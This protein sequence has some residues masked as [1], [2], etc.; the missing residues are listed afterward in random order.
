[1]SGIAN[2]AGA[3]AA[4]TL[5]PYSDADV[6]RARRRQAAPAASHA[7]PAPAPAKPSCPCRS[8][9]PARTRRRCAPRRRRAPRSAPRAGVRPP[10]SVSLRSRSASVSPTHAIG[11][12]PAASAARAFAA[13]DRV[14][15]PMQLPALRMADDRIAASELGDHPGRHLARISARRVLADVLR[16][17]RAP[18]AP[19]APPAPARD[20]APERTRRGRAHPSRSRSSRRRDDRADANSRRARRSSSSCRQR[21]ARACPFQNRR[22][23]RAAAGRVN[24]SAW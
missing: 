8:P 20:T 3:L 13:N 10:H 22:F 1:M 6:F 4:L 21:A 19:S 17:P 7:L 23:Y 15:L 2:S 11:V 24:A 5:P 9:T 16:T 18:R 14:R 12:S